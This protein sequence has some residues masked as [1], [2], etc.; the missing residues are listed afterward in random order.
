[1]QIR[2]VAHPA[3]GSH[4][5]NS[6]DLNAAEIGLTDLTGRPLLDEHNRGQKVGTCIASWEG[7]DG[8]LRV[9]ATVDNPSM[10]KRIANGSMRGLSLGTDVVSTTD[11]NVLYRGQAELSVCSEGRRAGTWID[12]INGKN[13]YRTHR[14][15]KRM[16]LQ[17]RTTRT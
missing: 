13:V 2:G 7:K 17:I 10:Q 4:R 5:E 16:P 15:S 14:A 8:S 1:M 3:P 12:T 9:A 11:D 6:A